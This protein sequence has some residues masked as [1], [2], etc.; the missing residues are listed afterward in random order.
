MADMLWKLKVRCAWG[1]IEP[2]HEPTK[3]TTCLT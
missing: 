3:P 1:I 2:I